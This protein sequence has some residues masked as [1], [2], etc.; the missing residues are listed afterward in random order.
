MIKFS[1]KL[2]LRRLF[3]IRTFFLQKRKL[4]CRFII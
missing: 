1:I 2:I 4:N 3:I